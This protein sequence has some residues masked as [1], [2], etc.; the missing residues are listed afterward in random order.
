MHGHWNVALWYRIP[1]SFH[2]SLD[3]TCVGLTQI[4]T[5]NFFTLSTYW[6]LMRKSQCNVDSLCILA[7]LHDPPEKNIAI[8]RENSFLF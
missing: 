7:M 3:A 2:L 6:L 5:P 4:C 1:R 8:V